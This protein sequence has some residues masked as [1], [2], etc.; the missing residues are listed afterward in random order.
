MLTHYLRVAFR[1]FRRNKFYSLINIGC[2]ALGIAAAMT[3]LLY[4]LHEHTY[5]R[6]QANNKRIF[7][8]SA[9]FAWGT[10]TYNSDR[11]SFVTGPLVHQADPR[12]KAF[13]RAFQVY[14]QP[15]VQPVG[16]KTNAPNEERSFKVKEHFLFAD[17]NFFRFFSYRLQRGDP[18][19]V[20]QRP[21]T[22][23]LSA[24]AARQYFG[25]ADPVG[26]VL[27]FNDRYR[28]E[29]TGVADDPPSNSSIVFDAVA[30]F[31]SCA[32]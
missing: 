9:T 23:V 15:V 6:W 8:V 20:L 25:N 7:A 2:L 29:V 1:L 10:S 12:V 3:I 17:S 4:V 11:L 13:I 31:S 18:A 19:R 16:N 26:K 30:S 14:E 21:Y 32:P 28:L 5:D 27:M 24:R 22:V